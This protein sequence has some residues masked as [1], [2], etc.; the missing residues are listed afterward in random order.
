MNYIKV[1]DSSNLTKITF[2][3]IIKFRNK[4]LS[5]DKSLVYSIDFQTKS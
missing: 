3:S 4:M 2:V 1:I 5:K